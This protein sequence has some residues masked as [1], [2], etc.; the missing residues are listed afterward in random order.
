[1]NNYKPSKEETDLLKEIVEVSKQIQTEEQYRA[2]MVVEIKDL[3][4]LEQDKPAGS[5][6]IRIKQMEGLLNV[7]RNYHS[8]LEEFNDKQTDILNQ[9][10]HLFLEEKDYLQ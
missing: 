3:L 6:A 10:K 8:N 9:F 5:T 2:D 1:M 7:I 4:N